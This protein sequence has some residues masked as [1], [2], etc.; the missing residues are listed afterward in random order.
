M[1]SATTVV[2]AI[3]LAALAGASRAAGDGDIVV[4]ASGFQH[5]GGH[6]IARLFR[7]GDDVRGP[8]R[9]QLSSAIESG[10]ATFSFARMPAGAYAVVVFHDANDNA[11]VDHNLQRLPTEALGFSNAFEPGLLNGLPSF[12]KLRFEHGP[13]TQSLNI[14]VK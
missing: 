3:V 9:W 13:Q 5:G 7:P 4:H 6:A 14:V 1:R 2:A 10:A 12:D 8:G 11:R